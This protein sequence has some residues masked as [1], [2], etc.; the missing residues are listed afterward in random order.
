MQDS[1]LVGKHMLVSGWGMVHGGISDVLREIYVIGRTNEECKRMLP[2]YERGQI[3]PEML[4]AL[5]RQMWGDLRMA[6]RTCNSAATRKDEYETK[7]R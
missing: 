4:C 7:G 1:F 3:F 2:P 6:D 5:Q